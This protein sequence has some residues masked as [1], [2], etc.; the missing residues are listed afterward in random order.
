[1]A[2]QLNLICIFCQVS[3]DGIDEPNK[4]F[5]QKI[6]LQ[7]HIDH[8]FN[9][10]FKY[11][12]QINRIIL[13]RDSG[14][15]TVYLGALEDAMLMANEIVSS[16]VVSSQQGAAPLSIRIGIHSQAMHEIHDF[17]QHPNFIENGINAAKQAMVEAKPNE[18]IVSGC[19]N[20]NVSPLNQT[21]STKLNDPLDNDKN[22]I[23][24]AN[25]AGLNLIQNLAGNQET[26]LDLPVNLTS[27][28]QAFEST[29]TS[30]EN[31]WKYALAS[32]YMVVLL[33]LLVELAIMPADLPNK[34]VKALPTKAIQL[35]NL[36]KEP[37][38]SKRFDTSAQQANNDGGAVLAL[39]KALG[40]KVTVKP[41][42]AKKKVD[43][44]TKKSVDAVANKANRDGKFSWE[45]LKKS[46]MQGQKKECTQAEN[47]L[48][49]CQK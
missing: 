20:E 42:P 8:L 13:V 29:N 38:K 17:S 27:S 34:Q 26:V 46:I 25:L 45:S 19:C 33:F 11:I 35:S 49:Q 4:T 22:Q 6:V 47:A 1:M 18:I 43:Q 10:A 5:A 23:L 39:P 48:N 16:I 28:V 37:L 24:E 14:A 40:Q 9:I 30:N 7:N 3:L 44:K 32:L 15:E 21:T 41:S 12:G 2:D 36:N 31:S